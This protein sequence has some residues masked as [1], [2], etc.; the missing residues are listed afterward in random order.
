MSV[1]GWFKQIN[2][3][4]IATTSKQFCTSS[5]TDFPDCAYTHAK[6]PVSLGNQKADNA[7]NQASLHVCARVCGS[8]L[9]RSRVCVCLCVSVCV[10]VHACVCVC[11]SLIFTLCLSPLT[12]PLI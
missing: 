10:C 6:D 2:L 4:R 5:G 3:E 9:A 7:T 12:Q 8:V 1:C 11:E